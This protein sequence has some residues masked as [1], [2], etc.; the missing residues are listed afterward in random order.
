MSLGRFL[1]QPLSDFR[2][3]FIQDLYP[4]ARRPDIG[5]EIV[6]F[7]AQPMPKLCPLPRLGGNQFGPPP[8]NR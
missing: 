4:E 8:E 7:E 2:W 3:C 1:D 6:L 5:F